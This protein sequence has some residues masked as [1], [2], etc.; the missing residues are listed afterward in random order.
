MLVKSPNRMLD[1]D[2]VA[3]LAR[4]TVNRASQL[5]ETIVLMH[6]WVRHRAIWTRGFVMG[7]L[8]SY[9]EGATGI[10]NDN[11]SHN[12]DVVVVAHTIP[13]G[14]STPTIPEH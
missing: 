1:F 9:I 3:E 6:W 8:L 5:W 14:P 4:S 7:Y 12:D 2:M 13:S 10:D 11:D